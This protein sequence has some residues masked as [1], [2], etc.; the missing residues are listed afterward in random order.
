[1]AKNVRNIETESALVKE[2][3]DVGIVQFAIAQALLKFEI[4]GEPILSRVLQGTIEGESTKVYANLITGGMATITI[5][6][7]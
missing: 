3:S 4:N 6:V 7:K 1:M 5:E 2:I